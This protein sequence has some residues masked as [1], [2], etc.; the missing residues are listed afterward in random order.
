[1]RG[2]DSKAIQDPIPIPKAAGRTDNLGESRTPPRPARSVSPA[3]SVDR[4]A[5]AA[6]PPP[7]AKQLSIARLSLNAGQPV[8]R[9]P[10]STRAVARPLE[11]RASRSAAKVRSEHTDGDKHPRAG[12]NTQHDGRVSAGQAAF[13]FWVQTMPRIS[14]H[15]GRRVRARRRGQSLV[16]FALISVLLFLF[17]LG[18]MEFARLLFVY[19]VVSNAA[20][21]GSRYGIVRPRDVIS[22]PAATRTA[23]AGGRLYSASQ[24]VDTTGCNVTDKTREKVWGMNPSAMDVAVWYDKGD[25]VPI[26]PNPSTPVPYDTQAIIK[27]NRVVVETAYRFHFL[28]PL[29]S[30]FAPEGLDVRMRSARTILQ[31]GDTPAA[32]C[33][34]SYEPPPPPTAGPTHTPGPSPTTAPSSTPAPTATATPA[35]LRIASIEAHKKPSKGDKISVKVN[36]VDYAGRPF[37]GATVM[38]SAYLNGLPTPYITMPLSWWYVGIYD[39]CPPGGYKVGDTIAID[40]IVTA[41]GYT[42]DSRTRVPVMVG[43]LDCR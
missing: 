23:Q 43:Q 21:E 31:N 7:A 17:L 20:Q 16:E 27:G 4:D 42:G 30:A 9:A 34:L 32:P 39:G 2:M 33:T 18:I 24:V 26:V 35:A 10:A 6:R 37:P 3:Q 19:S 15:S 40:V 5:P 36:V 22:A 29:L 11:L 13:F 38:V 28:T 1:M 8:S 25:S 41:P 12:L 14:A